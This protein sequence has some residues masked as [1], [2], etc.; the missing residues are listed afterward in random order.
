MIQTPEEYEETLLFAC[1]RSL[2]ISVYV[3]CFYRQET[4]EF[5]R[6]KIVPLYI[7]TIHEL[8]S[9]VF[10]PERP[11]PY[12]LD[13]PQDDIYYHIRYWRNHFWATFDDTNPEYQ[14]CPKLVRLHVHYF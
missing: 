10:E 9:F 14:A 5:P 11:Y 3:K 1:R 4:F 13:K 12:D 6:S 7:N 8:K 2:L